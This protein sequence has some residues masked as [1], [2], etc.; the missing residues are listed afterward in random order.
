MKLPLLS[1]RIDLKNAYFSG[2][3]VAS[4]II[5]AVFLGGSFLLP[6]HT[7]SAES[8]NMRLIGHRDLQWRDSLQVVLKGNYAYIGHHRGEAFNP[9]TG[10]REDNGTTILDVADPREPKII[11]HIPGRRGAESR[12][13]Q[14]AE[15]PLPGKDFLL[16]NQESSGFT[17]FEVWDIT[18][19]TD[20]RLASTI[21]PFQAAHKSW[22][23]SAT[24]YAYLS[25]TQ[26][27][28]SG[29]HLV[30]YD[31]KNPYRPQ[32]VSNWGLPVQ[33]PG[34]AAGRGVSLH[35]PV[36]SG[37][38]AYLSY[39]FGGDMVILDITNKAAPKLVSHLQF[40]PP[41]PG[42]HTTVPFT[43]PSAPAKGSRG[44][45][46]VLVLSEEAF[47]HDCRE[48]RRQLHIVDAT[49]ETNPTPLTTFKVPDGDF[50]SRGGRFGP[51]QFAETRDGWLI[52]GTLL[53]IAYFNAGL[54]VVDV[55]DPVRPREV[56]FFIPSASVRA[57]SQ[58]R[59][60]IQTNDVDLDY[61]G[62][63]YMT[64][65]SGNGLHIVEYTGGN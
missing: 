65:R 19:R 44:V 47:S 57:Q 51:H 3:K 18:D 26:P 60:N 21:G 45:R 58:G 23:E 13:V 62:F 50:C 54:R 36:I 20:P 8:Q 42:I 64:D 38:R 16:R 7:Y 33:R 2:E 46:S 1:Q 25:A 22:W 31:L 34:N 56:G 9:L 29:Q 24:G 63:I 6:S 27:G 17:G 39:L 55:S 48:T 4:L 53:Y 15:R 28:W 37:N 61:R 35:H 30:I 14:V 32:F 40:S 52:G 11:A 49:D 5:G 43:V 10:K 59:K 12:A 41:S